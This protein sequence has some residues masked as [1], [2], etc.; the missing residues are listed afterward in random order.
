MSFFLYHTFIGKE[1]GLSL[2]LLR[3]LFSTVFVAAFVAPAFAVVDS[4]S[5]CGTDFDGVDSGSVG[6]EAVWYPDCNPGQYIPMGGSSCQTCLA[7]SYCSGGTFQQDGPAESDTF[8]THC[9][10]GLYSQSG[11]RNANDCGRILHVG[12]SVV[13]LHADR[14]TTPSLVVSV[15][16]T[17]YYAD[18]TPVSQGA[19]PMSAGDTKTLRIN[20]QGTEYTVHST[21]YE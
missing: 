9:A 21:M 8:I 4:E 1:K 17:Q 7:D 19:V 18:T 12:D 10:S 5:V 14:R 11:S 16:G 20:Y 3:L 2:M 6:L 15:D 13:Y